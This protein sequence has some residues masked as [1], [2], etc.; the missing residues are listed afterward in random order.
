M[1]DEQIQ[2]ATLTEIV[3]QLES[4]NY[5]CE[6]GALVNNAYF[7]ELKRRAADND[8]LEEKADDTF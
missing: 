7:I 1:S 5:K 2:S 4:C 8:E 6:A 3:Q